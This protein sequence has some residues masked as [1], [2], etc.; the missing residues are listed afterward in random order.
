M[1]GNPPGGGFV[2]GAHTFR[3]RQ[4]SLSTGMGELKILI[5]KLRAFSGSSLV[6]TSFLL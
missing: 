1:T 5:V 6:N 2:V 4:S 3:Y